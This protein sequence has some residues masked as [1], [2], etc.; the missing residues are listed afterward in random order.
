M[1]LTE[2]I[3]DIQEGQMAIA[4]LNREKWYVIKYKGE[5]FN[6]TE[7]GEILGMALLSYKGTLANWTIIK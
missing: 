2:M 1:T 6:C 7:D 4:K 3:D 5:L